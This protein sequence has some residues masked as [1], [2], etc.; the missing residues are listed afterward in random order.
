MFYAVQPCAYLL[1][2]SYLMF[3]RALS[4]GSVSRQK[5]RLAAPPLYA[6][7]AN[8]TW[9]RAQLPQGLKLNTYSTFLDNCYK[10]IEE[11]LHWCTSCH[12]V[13]FW[14]VSDLR[15]IQLQ[16]S[17]ISS[18]I[19]II[20]QQVEQN[21]NQF[22]WVTLA[23]TESCVT[24]HWYVIKHQRNTHSHSPLTVRVRNLC[25]LGKSDKLTVPDRPNTT[26]R[27]SKSKL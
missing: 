27:R 6:N 3:H 12:D 2:N 7:A 10:Q 22:E 26:T 16:R 20:L 1:H 11:R 18:S 21:N 4:H 13:S 17:V 5:G 23:W 8:L 19:S 25:G 24:H 15:L 14:K 9:G